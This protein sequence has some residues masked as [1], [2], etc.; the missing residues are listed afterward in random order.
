MIEPT[1]DQVKAYKLG[2]R[3]CEMAAEEEVSLS[4]YITALV[5]V[6]CRFCIRIAISKETLLNLIEG[7]YEDL[8]ET[9]ERGPASMH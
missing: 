9:H 6:L 5:T 1:E 3:I 4:A 7:S 2:N 8:E